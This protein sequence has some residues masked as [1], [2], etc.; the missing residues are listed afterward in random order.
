MA[1]VYFTRGHPTMY[2]HKIGYS[3]N[4]CR[5]TRQLQTGS[6]STLRIVATIGPLPDARLTERLLHKKYASVW[7][8]GEWY[9][10]SPVDIERECTVHE[11]YREGYADRLA[12]GLDSHHRPMFEHKMDV[13]MRMLRCA[14]N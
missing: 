8:R 10:L 4:V 7:I 2:I 14:E 12:S 3:S 9:A 5:R 13:F 6:L 1:F 11:I